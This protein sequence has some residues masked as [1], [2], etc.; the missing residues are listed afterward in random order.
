MQSSYTPPTHILYTALRQSIVFFSR[1]S[2]IN[3]SL[4]T[5]QGGKLVGINSGV[6]VEPPNV[7][8]FEI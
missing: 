6:T 1:L 8:T 3:V 2:E 4:C 7:Y 5:P